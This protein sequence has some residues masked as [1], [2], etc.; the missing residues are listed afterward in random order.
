MIFFAVTVVVGF[1][2]TM[3][4]TTGGPTGVPPL[5][6]RS[7]VSSVSTPKRGRTEL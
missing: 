2:P 5:F 4:E 3:T 6:R 7:S 1:R